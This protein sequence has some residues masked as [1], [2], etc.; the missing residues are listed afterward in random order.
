MKKSGW[1]TALGVRGAQR[2][3]ALLERGSWPALV[4]TLLAAVALRFVG[5]DHLPGLNGDEA[6]FP[7]HAA[8]W[9]AGVPWSELRTGTDLP[10]N[11]LFFGSVAAL[12][13][14]LPTSFWTVRLAAVMHSLLALALA[15]ASFLNRGRGS[16]LC[17]AP[18]GAPR[19]TRLRAPGLG[20]LGRDGG[21]GVGAGGCHARSLPARGRCLRLVPVGASGRGLCRSSSARRA[22]A[23]HPRGSPAP[24]ESA[25]AGR[26]GATR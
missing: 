24:P 22:L 3:V 9:R 5:L 15:F 14:L 4:A 18:G 25:T 2:S 10:M 11:P 7:V 8:E 16:A 20:P 26:A 6:F 12:Q 1:Q 19:T 23:T 21:A 13:G 17:T